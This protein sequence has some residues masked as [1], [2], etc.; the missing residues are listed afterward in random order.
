MTYQT[1][2]RKYKRRV[3]ILTSTIFI[4][5]VNACYALS[6]HYLDGVSF[7]EAFKQTSYT[8]LIMV[9]LMLLILL[10]I[11]AYLAVGRL[12]KRTQNKK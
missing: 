9:L 1:K 3:E 6:L 5:G 10:L 4:I 2:Q 8:T 12:I 7:W 11:F